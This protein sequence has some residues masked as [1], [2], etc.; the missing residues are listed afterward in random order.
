M[1]VYIG[2]HV[3]THT[4]IYIIIHI[5]VHI[6][7][8]LRFHHAK[9]CK[10]SQLAI[11]HAAARS[12]VVIPKGQKQK[13][14]SHL[15]PLSR[16]L[17]VRSSGFLGIEWQLD[18]CVIFETHFE[19]ILKRMFCYICNNANI[20]IYTYMYVYI[21]ICMYIYTYIHIYICIHIYMYTYIYIHIHVYIYIICIH[22]CIYIYIHTHTHIY[23]H[24]TIC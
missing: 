19:H 21:Y 6:I 11:F 1:C 17:R 12:P 15:W 24:M 7:K 10:L 2:L 3:H 9:P 14:Q 5:E 4:Y 16:L 20:Y 23:I 18:H 22:V 8:D 13:L